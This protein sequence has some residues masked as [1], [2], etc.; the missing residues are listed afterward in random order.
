MDIAN[1]VGE[2]QRL[3]LMARDRAQRHLRKRPKY[4]GQVR[5][6]EA[7][8][9]GGER[10][11]RDTAEDREMEV[12]GMEVQDVELVRTL[13]DPFQQHRGVRERIEDSRVESQRSRSTRH[14]LRRTHRVPAREQGDTVALSNQFLGDP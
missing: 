6:V 1:P 8:V 11:V 14:Q 12:V 10:A 7:A 9:Q 3:A 13:A 2:A 5:Q 4:H